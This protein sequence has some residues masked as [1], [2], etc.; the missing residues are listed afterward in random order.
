MQTHR[1]GTSACTAVPRGRSVC[2]LSARPPPSTAP[3]SSARHHLTS[4]S[5]WRASGGA[6]NTAGPEEEVEGDTL[7]TRVETRCGNC[8]EGVSPTLHLS[9]R[10]AGGGRRSLCRLQ[11]LQERLHAAVSCG[12]FRNAKVLF[13]HVSHPGLD[14]DLGRTRGRRRPRVTGHTGL[15]RTVCVLQQGGQKLGG[16]EVQLVDLQQDK[17]RCILKRPHATQ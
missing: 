7:M 13:P 4:S 8:W 2:R 15:W 6:R 12:L 11:F 3:S 9:E 5:I 1:R 17:P 16:A 10:D 14:A